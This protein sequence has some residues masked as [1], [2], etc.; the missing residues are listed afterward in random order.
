MPTTKKKTT[1]KVTKKKTTKKA[2][3]KKKP[4][5]QFT[6]QASKRCVEL[7]KTRI[8]DQSKLADLK[9]RKKDLRGQVA[10]SRG[11]I[12]SVVGA[13]KED[14]RG[15][16]N[17]PFSAKASKLIASVQGD[18]DKDEAKILKL[19]GQIRDLHEKI[20][21][22]RAEL[23]NTIANQDPSGTLFEELEEAAA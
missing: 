2:A 16:G 5:A 10:E 22:A 20:N 6:L 13:E 18:I 23:D 17:K 21:D 3:A 1:K 19:E 9:Q 7:V 15:D 12:D 8:E 11:E 4:A 14:G